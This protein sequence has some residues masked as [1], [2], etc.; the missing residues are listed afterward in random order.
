M[1]VDLLV[2]INGLSSGYFSSDDKNLLEQQILRYCSLQYLRR[3]EISH[4]NG[5]AYI[6]NNSLTA[7]I[8]VFFFQPFL[9]WS[10]YV[11][12]LRF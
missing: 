7:D 4:D 6:A 2:L 3:L 5:H 12:V 8:S 11:S 9:G 1:E 10:V